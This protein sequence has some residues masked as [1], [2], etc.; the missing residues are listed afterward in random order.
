MD[1]ME[2]I[3]GPYDTQHDVERELDIFVTECYLLDQF[4][5]P[6]VEYLE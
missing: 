4:P 1:A 2:I 3:M 5:N 6:V